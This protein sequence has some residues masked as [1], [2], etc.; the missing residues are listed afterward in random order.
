M[1]GD[2]VLEQFPIHATVAASD[3]DRARA[4]YES[5]LGLKPETEDPSGGLWY[6]F[7]EG[8]WL[9]VY[10][11][12]FAGTARNTV[13]GWTVTDIEA[14]MRDL[15]ARGVVFEEYDLGNGMATVDGLLAAGPYKACWFKD[16][17]GNIFEV[18][19]VE[20]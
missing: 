2:T 18:S 19:Q 14:V 6:Q 7:G 5:K 20:R 17:E 1:E 3:I 4:W 11:T 9:S 10:Q 12:G 13:A 8:S 16:S 15:R